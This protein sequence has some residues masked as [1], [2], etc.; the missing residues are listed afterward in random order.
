MT[1]MIETIAGV[2]E[3]SPL[4]AALAERETTLCLSQESHDAVLAPRDPGGLPHALRAA[5]AARMARHCADARLAAH[6]QER[7]EAAGRT[8]ALAAI[9]D[10]ESA[11]PPDT[12]F[13]AILRHVDLVSRSPRDATRADVAAL[14]GAGVSEADIV[15]L[16]EL[17]AFV[18]YQARVIAGLRLMG[19]GR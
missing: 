7:L 5:L 16:S 12:R 13:A 18:S 4:A 1:R 17:I 2:A 10:P 15:R 8:P 3:G 19:A 9:A 14:T 11:V 6:Y